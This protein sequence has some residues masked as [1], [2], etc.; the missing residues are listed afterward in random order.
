MI[1]AGRSFYDLINPIL[2]IFLVQAIS[3]MVFF[4]I[5]IRQFTVESIESIYG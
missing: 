4:E 1:E 2:R 5:V 3:F